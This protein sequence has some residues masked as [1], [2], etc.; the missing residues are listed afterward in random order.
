MQPAD[1]FTK[2][3]IRDLLFGVISGCPPFR[4]SIYKRERNV[5]GKI[6]EKALIRPFYSLNPT[7]FRNFA[8]SNKR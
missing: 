4:E 1:A 7:I 3:R 8:E 5:S 6:Q 2:L